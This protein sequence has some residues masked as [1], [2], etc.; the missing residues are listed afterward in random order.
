MG[1]IEQIAECARGDIIVVEIRG[2]IIAVFVK[3]PQNVRLETL[4][5]VIADFMRIDAVDGGA[6]QIDAADERVNIKTIMNDNRLAGVMNGHKSL[7]IVKHW[8]LPRLLE[9]KYAGFAS[10]NIEVRDADDDAL[11]SKVFGIVYRIQP[12]THQIV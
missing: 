12:N 4:F 3:F 2:E 11:P 5:F 6:T 9:L 10:E 7:Q 1:E 8:V